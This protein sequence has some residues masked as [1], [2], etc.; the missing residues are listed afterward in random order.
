MARIDYSAIYALQDVENIRPNKICAVLGRTIPRMFLIYTVSLSTWSEVFHSIDNQN[1]GA[2]MK[3]IG[4]IGG[5]SWE[6]TLEYYRLIN[7]EVKGRLGGL[8]SANC[9]IY[10]VDFAPLEEQMRSNDWDGVAADLVAGA[11]ALEKGGADFFLL[12]SNTIHK[13]ANQVAESMDIPLLHI[14]N[15]SGREAERKGLRKLGLLGT[16]FVMEEDFLAGHLKENFGLSILVPEQGHR[17]EIN[18]IIFEELCLG[19]FEEDSRRLFMKCIERFKENRAD[20]VVLG[21]TEIPMLV[22]Q[23]DSSLPVIDTTVLHAA[24]AVEKA[25]E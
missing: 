12:C 6:S 9:L 25:L 24:A 5:T 23:A 22:S 21:C 11:K 15:A 20:G 17:N 16:S 13:C 8:H 2:H 3:T 14:G 18:R 1:R 7:Q 10:S 19:K 4:M